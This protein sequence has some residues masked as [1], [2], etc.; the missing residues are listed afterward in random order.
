MKTLDLKFTEAQ[1]DELVTEILSDCIIFERVAD[2]MNIAEEAFCPKNAE[3]WEPE[4]HY[5]GYLKALP[6]MGIHNPIT[7]EEEKQA[8]AVREELGNIYQGTIKDNNK[9]HRDERYDATVLAQHIL[10]DWKYYLND[11]RLTQLK[12]AN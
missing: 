6:L 10:I 1:R 5:N 3:M 7:I 8:E 4:C 2:A 9:L 11:L 12:K